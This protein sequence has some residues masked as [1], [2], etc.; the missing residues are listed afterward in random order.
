MIV[1][2][3]DVDTTSVGLVEGRSD[4]IDEPMSLELSELVVDKL[5]LLVELT[6][7]KVTIVVPSL[8]VVRGVVS[9]PVFELTTLPPEV[10][11]EPDPT[12]E[13]GPLLDCEPPTLSLPDTEPEARDVKLVDTPSTVLPRDV[14]DPD[15]DEPPSEL[16]LSKVLRLVVTP[17]SVPLVVLKPETKD[18]LVWL[19]SSPKLT[20][21]EALELEGKRLV[22]LAP[23]DGSRL[24]I[25][26][27]IISLVLAVL[28]LALAPPSMIV[29]PEDE[30]KRLEELD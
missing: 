7:E 10:D 14:I 28:V 8:T 5:L 1:T 3:V 6:K 4:V 27:L 11:N 19:P 26:P 20:S 21:S 12:V 9:R 23:L 15:P 2:N 25:T 13:E 24:V 16:A 29:P 22:L 30:E 18:V 17:L